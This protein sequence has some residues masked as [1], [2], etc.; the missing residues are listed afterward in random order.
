MYLP[1]GRRPAGKYGHRGQMRGHILKNPG[2]V[3]F[4]IYLFCKY[5][6]TNNQLQTTKWKLTEFFCA[7]AKEIFYFGTI[8]LCEQILYYLLPMP[9]KRQLYKHPVPYCSTRSKMWYWQVQYSHFYRK[10]RDVIQQ[11]QNSLFQWITH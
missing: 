5:L 7:F 8:V 2:C 10:S 11:V 9:T 6:Y 3:V 1:K 4:I